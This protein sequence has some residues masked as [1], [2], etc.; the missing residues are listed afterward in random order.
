VILTPIEP[1]N[2]PAI[3]AAFAAGLP[4]NALAP[5][6]FARICAAPRAPLSPSEEDVARRRAIALA[7]AFGIATLDEEPAQAFSWDGKVVRSRSEPSVLLHEIAH[8]QICPAARRRLPDFGLGAGPETG[9]KPEADSARAT[10]QATQEREE[11][12]ASLLGILWEAQLDLP[13]MAAFAEQNWLEGHDRAGTPAYFATVI[14]W[15]VDAGLIDV[16][17]RPLGAEAL[18]SG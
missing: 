1:Q 17:A 2:L 16:A 4:R 11:A 7:H 15:L 14:G 5:A 8:W 9:R 10:D 6:A 12:M 18:A 13:A 3:L